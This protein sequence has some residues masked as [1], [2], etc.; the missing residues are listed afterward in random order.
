MADISLLPLKERTVALIGPLT[1]LTQNIAMQLS[2][3]GA[4]IA[5]VGSDTNA[6]TRLATLINDQREINPKLGRSTVISSGLKNEKETQEA[7]S[8][9]VH[10]FGSLEILI[11]A[12]ILTQATAIRNEATS[13]FFAEEGLRLFQSRFWLAKNFQGF[14]KN[15]KRGRILFLYPETH[16][17]GCDLDTLGALINGGLENFVKALGVEMQELG[18]TANAIAIGPTEEYLMNHFPEVSSVKE[19]LEKLKI[20]FPQAKLLDNE[21]VA[22]GICFLCLPQGQALSG[23]TLS[24]R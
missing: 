13:A 8:Q 1:S 2:E 9:C 3:Q 18:A 11:D 20:V 15:R 19:A 16:R 7:L 6:L 23:Q 5:L 10:A 14:L 4:D 21:K 22:Q 24:L 17:M 12:Q